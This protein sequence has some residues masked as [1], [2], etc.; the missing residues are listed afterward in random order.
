MEKVNGKL[1]VIVD[2]EPAIVEEICDY[3][4][5][6]GYRAE[7]FSGVES[8]FE[9]LKR[10]KPDLIILDLMLPGMSGYDICRILK[11]KEKFAAIPIIMLSGKSEEPD[12][13]SGLDMGA[14]DYIVKPFSFK[15]LDARIRAVLRRQEPRGEEKKISIGGLM[16]IDLQSY[17]VT[18]EGKKVELTPAEF[19]ILELLSSQKNRV[20]T[21]ERILDYLWK[22]EKIVV[23]RTIDVHIRHLR[24][25]L[26][27]VGKFIKNVRGVGYKLEEDV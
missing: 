16:E 13:V 5:V 8:L 9:F 25:K 22:K 12:K 19:K 15:E 3:L 26:G 6:R 1:I 14:D 17:E 2:D 24:E 10:E 7:G 20:F 18:L 23:E 4:N 11:G 21:R 27:E